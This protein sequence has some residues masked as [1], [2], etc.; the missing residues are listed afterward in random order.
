[1]Q[2]AES[3]LQ[4]PYPVELLLLV[5]S[6]MQV[7]DTLL[8]F[9]NNRNMPHLD[10]HHAAAI[11]QK[12]F[13][14]GDLIR[15][16]FP[17]SSFLLRCVR[18]RKPPTQPEATTSYGYPS[19]QEVQRAACQNV[20]YVAAHM[21]GAMCLLDKSCSNGVIASIPDRLFDALGCLACEA[22]SADD[23]AAWH[24]TRLIWN[25]K[26]VSIT[27]HD[28]NALLYC[29]AMQQL[30]R[31]TAPAA[32]S[33]G[34]DVQHVLD[35]LRAYHQVELNMDPLLSWHI[36]RIPRFGITQLPKG[37]PCRSNV[38]SGPLLGGDDETA[39]AYF[40]PRVRDHSV[41]EFL[42][43]LPGKTS[44]V[45]P[46][47]GYARCASETSIFSARIAAVLISLQRCGRGWPRADPRVPAAEVDPSVTMDQLVTIARCSSA[48]ATQLLQGLR[49][50]HTAC[51]CNFY[52][53]LE[54]MT[55]ELRPGVVVDC[56]QCHALSE[57]MT[58][59]LL[60]LLPLCK[61][62]DPRRDGQPTQSGESAQH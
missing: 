43:L 58:A 48:L 34:L 26:F 17:A 14:G 55:E 40:L 21:F 53:Q 59:M 33:S 35:I 16:M 57:A 12:L 1:M 18:K 37:S 54:S 31:R 11:A 20:C 4:D 38:W 9:L 19:F 3:A 41:Q 52:N 15:F 45:H 25:L 2:C 13:Y 56:A 47:L 29:S 28:P 5:A 39:D 49:S 36:G 44:A 7:V 42:S 23:E 24:I 61:A 30:S 51:V 32:V 22:L 60:Q 46:Q 62:K 10:D 50:K 6:A 27:N 8:V